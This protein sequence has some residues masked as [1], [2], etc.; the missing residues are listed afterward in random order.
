M[1]ALLCHIAVDH[2]RRCQNICC[3]NSINIFLLEF[4]FYL[5]FD[6]APPPLFFYMNLHH[7]KTI[8]PL[9]YQVGYNLLV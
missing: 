4:N 7:S 3:L 5:I 8:Y 1:S 2:K 9:V 6:I